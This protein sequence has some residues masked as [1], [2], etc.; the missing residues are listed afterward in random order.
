MN[1]STML[2]Q[3]RGRARPWDVIIVGGGATGLGA[4]IDAASRGYATLLVEQSDFAKGTSSRS[5][6]LV[7]GGVRYL[8]QGQVGLVLSA[9]RERGLM[10][11]NAP[12]L[13]RSQPFVVPC[14]SRWSRLYYTVGLKTYDLLAGRL[15]FGRSRRLS[16]RATVDMLPTIQQAGLRGGVLY[17]DGQFDDA[18]L[19]VNLAQTAAGHGACVLNYMKMTGLMHEPDD[20]QIIERRERS[21]VVVNWTDVTRRVTGV[22]LE[23]LETGERHTAAGRVVINAT[24]VYADAIRRMDDSHA[25]DII[26]PSQGAHIVLDR[27]F[28]PGD[29]AVMVPKTDDGRVLFAIPWQGVVVV[30]TTDIAVRETPLEPRPIEAELEFLLEHAGRYLVRAPRREDVLSVF[31]GLRPL[32]VD[33]SAAAGATARISRDHALHVSPAGLVTIAGGK[34]TTYRKMAQDVVDRAAA[35]GDLDARPC[36]TRGLRIHGGSNTGA[37][38]DDAALG[39]YGSD[40]PAVA[41]LCQSE[42]RYGQLIHRALPYR[43]GQVVW[44]VRH[45][46]AR[47]VEDV[48]ARR[49]RAL[50]LSARASIEAGP[51]VARLMAGELGR[52]EAWQREQVAAYE[53]IARRYV[54]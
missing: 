34:W 21:G 47:T 50:V 33:A 13:V 8:R 37:T 44:A 19:A 11:R 39:Q 18:R 40:A 28:L 35:V 4:A 7:H 5:T 30:G 31:A 42:P 1:R 49:T 26:R 3:L 22:E 15:G 54:W 48:L 51:Y 6:K 12:H 38:P 52:D 32:V 20:T 2:E 46:M 23:D 25:K 10:R 27:S 45:E 24:G 41:S 29:A 53:Q 17:H 36:V 14:Y 43:A 9:L 16:A